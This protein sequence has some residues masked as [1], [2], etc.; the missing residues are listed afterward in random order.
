MPAPHGSAALPP[1]PMKWSDGMTKAGETP[2]LPVG[3]PNFILVSGQ[4]Q[5]N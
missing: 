2:A 5:I 4:V 1:P 3:R